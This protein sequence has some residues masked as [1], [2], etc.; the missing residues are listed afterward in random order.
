MEIESLLSL[1]K[2]IPRDF[3]VPIILASLGL[4]LFV[5]GMIQYLGSTKSADIAPQTTTEAEITPVKTVKNIQVDVEGGVFR[6]G[7]YTV[8]Y[9][10][11]VQDAL[12]AAGG[13]SAAADRDYV[14]KHVNLA[15]RVTDGAKIYIPRVGE[16]ILD[17]AQSNPQ[18]ALDAA[19][20][21]NI[22]SA[23]SDQLD[24]LPG[25]GATTAQKI[26]ANR[27][28]EN[29]QDLLTKKV[30]GQKVFNEIKDKLTVF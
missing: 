1:L 19:G 4:M 23:T 12:V 10:S 28:Y 26:I 8:S 21:I 30:V 11:R 22:N 3:Y 13:L 5:Y 20:L 7:V 2:K 17:G 18:T 15:Q 6:P 9:D 16:Q 27:P 14:A 24:S 25:I 29:V